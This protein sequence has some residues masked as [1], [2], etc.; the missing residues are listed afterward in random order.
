MQAIEQVANSTLHAVG[1]GLAVAALVILVVHTSLQNNTWHIVSVSVYG[2][3]LVLL[4]LV[5][6]LYHSFQRTKGGEMLRIV[7]RAAIYLLI[8]GTYTPFTLISLR[9]GWGWSIFGVIWG[10]ALLGMVLVIIA[11]RKLPIL[12]CALYLLMG[13]LVVVASVPALQSISATGMSW[14]LAGGIAYTV[15]VLFFAS[16]RLFSHTVWH[17]TVLCG[18]ACH[19][20]AVLTIINR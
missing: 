16:K 3:T 15:G 10:L 6:T 4:Y 18:S 5:S 11:P 20:L 12:T 14:L 1:F 7:D 9:G 8:A 13:W 2:A 19:F 17:L